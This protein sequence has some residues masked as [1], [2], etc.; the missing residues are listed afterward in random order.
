MGTSRGQGGGRLESPQGL[1]RQRRDGGANSQEEQLRLTIRSEVSAFRDG[2]VPDDKAQG[3]LW[4]P[5]AERGKRQREEES[6]GSDKRVKAVNGS[7]TL[8]PLV[9]RKVRRWQELEGK[10]K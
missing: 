10:G 5:E 2:I 8:D 6:P 3:M 9:T 4:V 7:L 1:N